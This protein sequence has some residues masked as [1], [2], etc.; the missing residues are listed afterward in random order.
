MRYNLQVLVF[1]DVIQSHLFREEIRLHIRLWKV[2]FA[3]LIL[4]TL[5]ITVRLH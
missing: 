4:T 5:N 2:R 3:D 1:Q